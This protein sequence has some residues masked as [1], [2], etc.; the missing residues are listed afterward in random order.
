[1]YINDIFASYDYALFGENKNIQMLAI[2]SAY[3]GKDCLFFAHDGE[4]T[5]GTDHVFEAVSRGAVAVCTD[6]EKLIRKLGGIISIVLVNDTRDAECYA[7]SRFYHGGIY[8][9]LIGVTGTNGKTSVCHIAK[10]IFEKIGLSC[11]YVGTLGTD[12]TDEKLPFS[13][14]TLPP[15]IFHRLL[16]IASENG[17]EYVFTE[18]SSQGILAKRC[19]Y[20]DYHALIFTNLTR[21]HLDTHKNMEN[22]YDAKSS[23]FRNNKSFY[24]INTDDSYG[25]RLYD[26]LEGVKFSVG[27]EYFCD[28]IIS[29][30]IQSSKG[31]NFYLTLSSEPPVNINAAMYGL[32]NA[33]NIAL[34]CSILYIEGFSAEKIACAVNNALREPVKGRMERFHFCGVDVYVDYAHTPDA[35]KNALEA[36]NEICSGNIITVFGCGGDR[37]KEKRADMGR[38][39]C[40]L[41]SKVII[42]EDNCRSEAFSGISEDILSGCGEYPVHVIP[43]RKKAIIY[44]LSLAD[45]GDCVMILGRG[46]EEILDNGEEKLSFSDREFIKRLCE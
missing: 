10:K 42:T 9:K 35:V 12:I 13:N 18:L 36:A 33:Y 17:C 37:D 46:A 1:M 43:E 11:S 29:G 26:E 41:S 8:P 39:A 45:K 24:I 44:A 19:N 4:K 31:I 27:K 30:F 34:V 16:S 25:E 2:H 5:K 32:F 14:T 6:D 15:V 3:T 23:I 20:T 38:L 28:M 40:Q 22:Y 7:A 21:D